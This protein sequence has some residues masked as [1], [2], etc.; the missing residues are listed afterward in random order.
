MSFRKLL[1]LV[2]SLIALSGCFSNNSDGT[3]T[4]EASEPEIRGD[5]INILAMQGYLSFAEVFADL[6][7][8]GIRS[9]DEPRATTDAY[10]F[11]SYRP[12]IFSANGV[13]P[14][15]DYCA[16][17][18]SFFCLSVKPGSAAEIVVVQGGIDAIRGAINSSSLYGRYSTQ[19]A[20]GLSGVLSPLSAQ[21]DQIDAGL[22]YLGFN[23]PL[24]YSSPS[25]ASTYNSALTTASLEFVSER[26]SED[27]EASIGEVIPGLRNELQMAL[28]TALKTEQAMWLDLSQVQKQTVISSAMEAV[29]TDLGLFDPTSYAITVQSAIMSLGTTLSTTPS[30]LSLTSAATIKRSVSAYFGNYDNI[31]TAFSTEETNLLNWETARDLFLANADSFISSVDGFQSNLTTWTQSAYPAWEDE[32]IN[33]WKDRMTDKDQPDSFDSQLLDWQTAYSAERAAY[34]DWIANQYEPWVANY[35]SGSLTAPPDITW[36]LPQPPM[37]TVPACIE[38]ATSGGAACTVDAVGGFEVVYAG[39]P[40]LPVQPSNFTGTEPGPRPIEPATPGL[41]ATAVIDTILN[42]ADAFDALAAAND[43]PD[44]VSLEEAM[45]LN[46][47]NQPTR[48]TDYFFPGGVFPSLAGKTLAAVSDSTPTEPFFVFFEPEG[49][50]GTSPLTICAPTSLASESVFSVFQAQTISAVFLK[51]AWLNPTGRDLVIQLAADSPRSTVVHATLFDGGDE[52]T[53]LSLELRDASGNLMSATSVA[54]AVE[55][56]SDTSSIPSTLTECAQYLEENS[57]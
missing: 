10:G 17:G 47:L 28:V 9:F 36:E 12:E 2:I 5:S 13:I 19:P 11:V 41:R 39:P 56:I 49:S 51:G 7:G 52:V 20:G 24:A 31:R 44:P 32:Y 18:P 48:A 55:S 8:N 26:I 35:Q 54:N 30:E 14:E 25:A 45:V 53:P 29:S 27:A 57:P 1:P 50:S 6:D 22:D 37:N 43:V 40:A 42:D 33:V 16:Q 21:Q 34:Q 38:G 4:T 23:T 46:P 15:R 3:D